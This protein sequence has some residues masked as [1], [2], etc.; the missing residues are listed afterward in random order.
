[1]PR[2]GSPTT[3][4]ADWRR[5]A[6]TTAQTSQTTFFEAAVKGSRLRLRLTRL[7]AACILSVF[8]FGT[9]YWTS[10][11]P[12][13]EKALFLVGIALAGFGAAGRAWATS[14]ISGQKQKQLITSGPYS[15]CRNPLYFFGMILGLGFGFCTRTFTAPIVITA[16]LSILHYYQI[17]RE[18]K[19]LRLRFGNQFDLYV[20]NVPRL[21]PSFRN[22]TE[23]D[24][25]RISPRLLK[26]GLFGVAFL[27]ILIGAL[28]LI[29]GLHQIG[30]LPDLFHIY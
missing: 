26:R 19:R 14:Y 22:Y 13:L 7:M 11:H 29:Q 10:T 25:I 28:D 15:I 5:R 9:P 23:P 4:P 27:L 24:E 16:V 6:R 17:R 12:V 1:M 8:C 3:A 18:E 30:F 21:I 2:V 20:A